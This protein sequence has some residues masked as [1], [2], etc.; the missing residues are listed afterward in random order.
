MEKWL[1]IRKGAPFQEISRKFGIDPVIAR[2]IRNRE[3]IG[4]EAIE[5]YLHAD[6]TDLEDPLALDGLK[7]AAFL[8]RERI[9]E[10]KRIRVIGDYDIDGVCATYILEHILQIYGA[11]AICSRLLILFA[12]LLETYAGKLWKNGLRSGRERPFRRSPENSELTR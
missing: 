3:I 7:E 2:I 12:G 5:A 4:D 8:L 6:L 1:E 9:R 11:Q 10:G